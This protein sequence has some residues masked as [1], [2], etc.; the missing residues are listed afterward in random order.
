MVDGGNARMNDEHHTLALLKFNIEVPGKPVSAR[1]RITNAGNPTGN[2][3]RICLVEEAWSETKV[4]YNT[5]PAVGRELAQLGALS[6]N[7]VAEQPIPIDLIKN[8][9]LSLI[10]DATSTDGG[11]FLSRES[12]TPAELVV[13]YEK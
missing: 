6:E 8:G 13:E 1:I 9:E 11:D 5:R 2:A 4:T 3:G 10:I 7:Q 12:G